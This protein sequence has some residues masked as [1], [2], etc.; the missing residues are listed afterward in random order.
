LNYFRLSTHVSS[1][2]RSE[3]AF[4]VARDLCSR[5]PE[6]LLTAAGRVLYRHLG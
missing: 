5:M 6:S 2:T 1:R 4:R 3:W